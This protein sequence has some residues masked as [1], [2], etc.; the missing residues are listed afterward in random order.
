[1]RISA[2]F[3]LAG[4]AVSC[5]G[6][7][8]SSDE[9]TSDSREG[10]IVVSESLS[11][12]TAVSY[13][14]SANWLP[15]VGTSGCSLTTIDA[16]T[17][18]SCAQT[19]AAAPITGLDAGPLVFASSSGSSATLT[20]DGSSEY[21]SQ[22]MGGFFAPGDMVTVT[23]QGGPD[24]PSFAAVSVVAPAETTL[25]DPAC[26]A[27]TCPTIDRTQDLALSWTS[28]GPGVLSI[29][30]GV[31]A[32]SSTASCIFD[33]SASTGSVPAEVLA[34]FPSRAP[35]TLTV[36]AINDQPFTL[37]GLATAFLAQETIAVGDSLPASQ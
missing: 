28:Q 23:G 2:A 15:P 34:A 5:F 24:L 8:S 25:L 14:I 19:T 3:V 30:L 11:G 22:G 26:V 31:T 9:V 33:L 1:M 21:L 7:G 29:N 27:G 36:A 35:L 10:T 32:Q 37:G 6:C 13:E 20:A 16:C 18:V 4:A 17:V 12:S